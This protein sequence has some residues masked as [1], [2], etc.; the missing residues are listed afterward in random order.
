MKKRFIAPAVALASIAMAL[1]SCSP[2]PS[3]ADSSS[4]EPTSVEPSSS[5][6]EQCVPTGKT[7]SSEPV[8]DS[9]PVATGANQYVD[10]SYAERRT[11]LGKL[12][13]Y[14]VDN[15]IAGLPLYSDSG[16]SLYN[17]RVVKGTN[18]YVTGYGFSVL[19]DGSLNGDLA[20]ESDSKYQNYYHTWNSSDPATLNAWD[21]SGS[22]VPDLL[23]YCSTGLFGTKLNS[24]K[25]GYE[26]EGVLAKEV[27]G[28]PVGDDGKVI[29]SSPSAE[30]LHTTWRWHI[31][32]GEEGR[33]K[34]HTL[35]TKSDRS[36]YDDR[37][38]AKED[39][40]TPFIMLLNAANGLYRGSELAQQTG[41]GAISGAST[42]YSMTSSADKGVPDNLIAAFSK[43]VGV[44]VGT[45][46]NGEDYLQVSY[47]LPVNRFYAMYNISDSL[48]QP[49]PAAFVNEVGIDNINGYN[50]DKS[51]TP[52]D[53]TLSVGPYTLEYWETD[54]LITF[55][56]NSD[57]YQSVDD[58]NVYSIG[59]VHMDI[60]TG[61][62]T[63][64]NIAFEQFINSNNLDSVGV[65]SDYLATYSSDPRAVEVPG[66]ST[67]K[68]N[69]NS[70]TEGLWEELFGENG[71][72]TR[73]AKSKYWNV[74][75][76]MS[77][78]NFIRGLFYS[79][80]RENY[81]KTM[82][83]TPSI[84]FFGDGYL[85]NPE[86]GESY[87]KTA[88]HAAALADFW[89]DTIE[90]NGYSASLSE[91]CFQEAIKELAA[92][93]I[94]TKDTKE[95]SIDIYWMYANQITTDG[96]LIAGYIKKAFDNAAQSLGYQVRLTVNQAE[97]GANWSD[98]Y[99]DHLLVGQFDLAFGSIS[100]N[101]LDPLN[102]LE[103]LKSSNSSGFT[104]NW[105][106]DTTDVQS[107][108]D[109]LVYD[110]KRWS[111]DSLW[112]AAD[113]GI[114]LDE[115]GMEVA[116]VTV[117][118]SSIKQTADTISVEGHV[119]VVETDGLVIDLA[120]IY[121]TSNSK[122][123]DYF[124]VY[125]D[126]S[127]Y[128]YADVYDDD[129]ELVSAAVTDAVW[130]D[131]GDFSFTIN[132]TLASNIAQVGGMYTFGVDYYITVCGVEGGLKSATCDFALEA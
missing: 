19:R 50:S 4:V 117:T 51:Y 1:V 106:S 130:D 41:K 69:I 120:D 84:N 17:P 32:T 15:A 39:Y 96:N 113:S 64:K 58:P 87:N 18:K 93:C 33:V 86:T 10:A 24:T 122:Y 112:G 44:S 99:Y 38:L 121:G 107:G 36:S 37:Y 72:V 125:P 129:D 105:G 35:S 123:S 42:F 75:P 30:E 79:I 54:K 27:Y 23:S 115:N 66:S 102:F 70:C 29:T 76:W 77:N 68:L 63:N 109:A 9:R 48:Y 65:P 8:A 89:G 21:N 55:K 97:G 22:V 80:D 12:E 131:D 6:E 98:V 62:K 95:I 73:T 26:W 56:K 128:S 40:L 7:D 88:E 53:N 28:S 47:S 94:I 34:Y 101:S 46:E 59:G 20:G 78:D 127:T 114:I 67:W 111:F 31:R 104:L 3:P 118:V 13:K 110:G 82:G 92:D 2:S 45:D 91:A 83:G 71:T 16:Y 108:D 61:Y 85:S 119:E 90:T 132:G 103:I 81:A 60:L 116:P 100:G 126:G 5:T 49:L 52:V 74:K 124:E 43:Y 57:W 14:A 11:I 25:D